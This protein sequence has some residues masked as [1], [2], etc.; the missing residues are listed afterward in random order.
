[1]APG[2]WSFRR[3]L[4]TPLLA[5]VVAATAAS[6]AGLTPSPDA[7]ARTA[8]HRDLTAGDAGS[9]TPPIPVVYPRSA[10]IHGLRAAASVAI[11]DIGRAHAWARPAIRYVAATNAWMRDFTQR[12]DGTF[13]FKPGVAETRKYFAR[14]VVEAFAP[15][16]VPDPTIV[17]SDLDPS[18]VWYAYGAV[19][20][21]H[22]WMTKGADGAFDP[23]SPVTMAV[24]HRALVLAL[25]LKPAAAA[26]NHLHMGNGTAFPVPANF[27]TTLLGM[28]L[29]LRYNAPTGQES[30]DVGPSDSLTREQVAYSL[31]HATTQPSWSVPDLLDQYKDIV[32]PNLGPRMTALVTWGVRYIGYPYVWGGEWGK[33][34]PEPAALGGQPRSGFDCSGLTWWLLRAD[35]HAQRW[36]VAPPRP[37]AGWHL[38]QRTS[39]GMAAATP[40]RLSFAKLRPGDIMFYDGDGDGVTDHVD[41]YIGNGYSLDSSSTPGGVTI[42]WV[43]DGWYRDH[44][45]YGRRIMPTM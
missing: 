1:M 13:A 6:L 21:K 35:D 3:S 12:S 25:G 38:P 43:G 42:M 15:T 37:Y 18:D 28:R 5:L 27:G 34:S 23:D 7:L 14:S 29:G 16:E 2:V 24:V 8:G 39:S 20:V 32:L 40:H 45:L 31:F 41:T 33:P 30:L 4:R 36:N 11:S 26:L 44:F 19:A 22:G 9:G 17:F 10:G